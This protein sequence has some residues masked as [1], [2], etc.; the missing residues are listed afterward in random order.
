MS[1]YQQALKQLSE[2]IDYLKAHPSEDPE[3]FDKEDDDIVRM[4]LQ[5][6]ILLP[7]DA[8]TIERIDRYYQKFFT[9]HQR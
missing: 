4:T 3:T 1:D 7:N 5:Q 9:E 8:T 2:M 6:R